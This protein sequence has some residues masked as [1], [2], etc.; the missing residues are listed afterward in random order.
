MRKLLAALLFSLN[1]LRGR[2]GRAWRAIHGREAVA[3]AL[4]IDVRAAKLSA[5]MV[6]PT[7]SALNRRLSRICDSVRPSSVRRL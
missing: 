1:L 2:T 5:F 7:F 4:G 3:E 6:S